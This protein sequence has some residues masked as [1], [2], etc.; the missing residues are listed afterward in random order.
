MARQIRAD[1]V[2]ALPFI[3]RAVHE[4]RRRINDLRIMWRSHHRVGPLETEIDIP[5]APSV[6]GLRIGRDVAGLVSAVIVAIKPMMIAEIDDV[7]VFDVYCGIAGFAVPVG[8]CFLV[9]DPAEVGTAGNRERAI[10]LLRA[11][12]TIGPLVIRN[13]VVEL[14]CRLIVERRPGAAAVEAH[15]G[16]AVVA[17]DHPHWILRID[18]E[19]VIIAVRRLHLLIGLA[20]VR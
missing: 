12:H 9:G 11:I 8:V 13:N 20:A 17:F 3:D 6:P 16:A 2:P 4:L 19:I 1:N 7:R 14:R 5:R 15:R 10:V 18:P